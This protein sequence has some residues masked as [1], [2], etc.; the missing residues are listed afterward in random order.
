MI[1]TACGSASQQE[2]VD[3]PPA[4]SEISPEKISPD[5]LPP[6]VR[7]VEH[8]LPADTTFISTR[9]LATDLRE[10]F[11]GSQNITRGATL[12]NLARNHEFYMDFDFDIRFA[13]AETAFAIYLDT[14][15]TDRVWADM[16]IQR[17]HDD[18]SIPEGHSRVYL[19]PGS[20]PQS[21]IWGSFTDIVT[22]ERVHLYESGDSHYLHDPQPGEDWGFLNHFYLVQRKDSSGNMLSYPLVTIFTLENQLDAPQSEF[23]VTEDGRGGFRWNAVEGADYYLVVYTLHDNPHWMAWPFA[24]STHTYWIHPDTAFGIDM[25]SAFRNLWIDNNVS[26]IAVNSQTRSALGNIHYWDDIMARLPERWEPPFETLLTAMRDDGILTFFVEGDAFVPTHKPILMHDGLTIYRRLIFDF[27][28]TFTS[29]DRFIFGRADPLEE[30]ENEWFVS[31]SLRIPFAIEGTQFV[32]RIGVDTTT[33]DADIQAIRRNIEEATPRAGFA[34]IAAAVFTRERQ[35]PDTVTVDTP[36]D[37]VIRPGE[38]IYANSALSAFL[39]H[40]LLAANEIIDLTYF[41]ESANF[42]YLWAAFSE[43]R[44]QNPF[45]MHVRGA[46]TIPGSNILRVN[47]HEPVDVILRQQEAVRQIVPQI[48]AEIITPGMSY[49]EM[50]LAINQF[51]VENAEYDFAALEYAEQHNFQH[52]HPRFND[53]FTAY[54]ILINRV[55]VCAGYAAAYTLLANEAGLRTIVVTGYMEGFIPHAWNRVYID[56]HWHIIDVTNNVSNVF[57][58]LYLHLPDNA[59]RYVLVQDRRF[60]LD[61]FLNN[62]RSDDYSSEYFRI[63]GRFYCMDTIAQALVRDITTNGY[64][65]LRTDFGLCD[66]AFSSIARR[67]MRQLGSGIYGGHKLGLIYMRV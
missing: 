3:L 47:Y 34:A 12:W 7:A 33:Y 29:D 56:G 6:A 48:I 17:H 37:V 52:V 20:I 11:A 28:N 40:N 46:S 59:A 57:P 43:A 32:G 10:E 31:S 1:F 45:I 38:H 13:D 51:L 67:V 15:L 60:V 62:Y 22:L 24:K 64:A 9:T 39:T 27:D 30:Y 8:E 35:A 49:L 4:S 50:S 54:G 19:S 16:R 2:A 26:V 42:D 53:S 36:H 25:N 44:Y 55:G 5:E 63:T 14:E 21:R 18:S 65:I 66:S 58:N 23:F 61:E 41:P